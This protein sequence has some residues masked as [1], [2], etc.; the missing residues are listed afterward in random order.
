MRIFENKQLLEDALCEQIKLD[1]ESAIS[2]YGSAFLLVSGGSTPKAFY[3]KLNKSGLDW[4]KI[5]VS[6]VDERFVDNTSEFSNEKLVRESLLA[7]QSEMNFI[8]MVLDDSNESKNLELATIAFE[9]L[10]RLDVVILGMGDDGH[11]ASIFPNNEESE[12]ALETSDKLCSTKAPN[13]PFNRISC[14]AEFLK[15]ASKTYLFF[16]GEHKLNVFQE[17]KSKNYPI[18][19]FSEHITELYYTN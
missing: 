14:S 13:V 7:N 5:T 2:Q 8:P 16:T 4:S 9:K 6:L 12:R 3:E 15:S 18:A 17:A 1:L 11:T 19:H 10:N